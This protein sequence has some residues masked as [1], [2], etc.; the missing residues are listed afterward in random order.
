MPWSVDAF[1]RARGEDKPVLLSISAVWCH[2]CHV[3]DETSYSDAAVID[4]IN[5]EF[6]PIRVDND[7]RP[8][9]NARYNMGGWPTTAFLAPDGSTLT[10]ATY[11]PPEQMRQALDEIAEF[12]RLHKTEIVQRA[13]ESRERGAS[14]KSGSRDE[15]RESMVIR[16]VEEIAD[17]YDEEFGGFGTAPK[18]PQPD[19]LEF[20][21]SEWRLAGD[22]RLYEMVAKSVIGMSHGGMYDHVEGGFFR[23]STTR[24]WS[25]P[26]F[27]KMAEDHAGL[28]RVLAQLVLV[29]ENK[30]FR[31][32]LRSA[33]EYVRTVLRD[34]RSG[35][36][37]GSQDADEAYFAFPLDERRTRKAP[38]VDRT[39]Y[40]NWTCALAGSLLLAGRALDDDEL[41]KE[42][43]ATLDEV[44]EALLDDEGLL[45]HVLSPGD[46]PSV[47]GL[48]ADQAAYLRALVDAHEVSGAQR[49]LERACDIADRVLSRFEAED[50]GFYDRIP[51][52]RPI[53]RLEISD[54][55]IGDNGT[56][57]DTL[58]RLAVLTNTDEYRRSAERALALYARSYGSA[59]A[60]ASTYGRALRRFLS[61][62]VAVRI[63][64]NAESTDAF[65]E[66]AFRLPTPLTVIRTVAPAAAE[67][68]G[69]PPVPEPA[70]YLCSG[71]ACAAPATAPER[72]RAA[73]D[74]L[75][76]PET[77]APVPRT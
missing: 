56:V 58:L 7:R 42:N 13:A 36:Y 35:L 10:G 49:F 4:T 63:V 9:I 17:G 74:S 14:P 44:A 55:P 43:L 28:I 73:Y 65:R 77:P 21:L 67:T 61:P 75:L 22:Q 72:V 12:Y 47:R 50:G 54:R 1:E 51:L 15:L 30:E 38:Y 32:T 37:A 29:S 6:V 8:D 26:H 45:Y 23:Y 59:G 71:S 46:A 27:E 11:L 40:S 62:E 20:L 53:G 60:F 66:V 31:A 5:R 70:A 2:W 39:S 57:A 19:V 34:S 33:K 41:V 3:M 52:E 25:V 68:V 76:H 69:L 18:F 24:D 48:L 16:L 64:G